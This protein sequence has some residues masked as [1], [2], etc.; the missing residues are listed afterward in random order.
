MSFYLLRK[1]KKGFGIERNR[2]ISPVDAASG[3]RGG[4]AD[5][6]ADLTPA[7]SS[8]SSSSPGGDARAG[9]VEVPDQIADHDALDARAQGAQGRRE[10]VVR[11]RARA[12]GA[13]EAVVE[14]RGGGGV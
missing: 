10:D 3:R 1:E 11:A 9:V 7:A 13:V 8:L 12:A 14:G 5:L 6:A 2:A 4:A